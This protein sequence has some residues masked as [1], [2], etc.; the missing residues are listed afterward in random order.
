MRIKSVRIRNFRGFEDETI[1]FGEHTCFVGPNGA[2]KSTVLSALNV[3]F[4]EASN[5]TSVAE[6]SEEDFHKANTKRPIEITVTFEGLSQAAKDALGHYVRH[7]ELVVS[8]VAAFDQQKRSATVEQHGERL[9]FK[10]FAPFFEDEKRGELVD[11]LRARFAQ[12]TDGLTNFPALGAKPTKAAMRNALRTYEEAHTELCELDRSN[13]KFYGATRGS[14]KLEPFVQWVYVPAVKDASDEAEDAGNTALAKLLQRTVRQ[15]LNFDEALA[16]LEQETRA[17]YDALLQQEQSALG[18]VSASLAKRL[19]EF[20]HPN[21][22]VVVEWLQGSDKSVLISEPRAT[23]RGR[24]G[25][26]KGSLARFGHGFQRSFLLAI[27]QELAELEREAQIEEIQGRPTLILACE[28]PELYQHPPQARHLSGMLRSLTESGN[29]V[30][31]TTHSPYFVSS[32]TFEEIRL[33]RK[34]TKTERCFV[35]ATD[36]ARFATRV[37]KAT[38]TQPEKPAVARAKLSAALRPEQSELFFCQRVVL[39]E[40]LEDRAYVSA[41]LHLEGKW[42]TVRKSGLHLIVTDGKD[43]ILRLLA[44]AQELQIP[45]F[46]IFDADGDAKEQHKH[47]HERDNRNL[48]SALG[49]SVD[50][51]PTAIAMGDSYAIW[52][53][54]LHNEIKSSF[55]DSDWQLLTNKAR[56]TIDPGAGLKKNPMLIGALLGVMWHEE[57]KPKLLTDLTSRLL[58]FANA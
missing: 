43:S 32:E 57:K 49:I 54:T 46:V 56:Q 12:V 21:A 45:S 55:A 11:T 34:E 35:R 17:K 41:A 19:A 33:V 36:F 26:F 23:I 6:L 38:G 48:I 5:A 27:L 15:K 44:I 47:L 13:D 31:L 58:S 42:D 20:S 3:F 39:V 10:A 25:A 24:E 16:Q 14:G 50:A 18:A 40:G 29:Q 8:A 1:A 52:P 2:G 30:V 28:E 4:Q 22:G 9:I 37:A 51:F 53:T 7:D